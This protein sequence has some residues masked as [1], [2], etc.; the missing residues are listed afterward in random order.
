MVGIE[1]QHRGGPLETVRGRIVVGADGRNSL[2]ARAVEAPTDETV[3]PQ[4]CW[5]YAYWREVPVNGLEWYWRDGSFVLG[6]PTTDGLTCVMVGKPIDALRTMDEAT[7]R[8]TL[9]IAPRFEAATEDREPVGDYTTTAIPNFYRRPHGPGWA[10]V[11]D[12]GLCMDPLMG[13]GISDAFCDAELLGGAI[14]EGLTGRTPMEGA[15]WDYERERNERASTYYEPNWRAAALE[16]W[17]SP[18]EQRLRRA[19]A[20]TPAQADRWAGTIARSVD[21]ED[22]YS[23][24]FV[25]KARAG[26]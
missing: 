24:R 25:E 5:T 4:A 11:G 3:P 22:F 20:D 7:Y 1:G 9:A 8:E 14:D 6:I 2:V 15:L 26:D 18:R 13:H 19:I 17:D 16:G 23:S 21:R 10:L 12:A